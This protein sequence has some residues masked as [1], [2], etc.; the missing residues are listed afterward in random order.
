MVY[1]IIILILPHTSQMTFSY[2]VFKLYY[3]NFTYPMAKLIIQ[4]LF[5]VALAFGHFRH[6]PRPPCQQVSEF[7]DTSFSPRS[8]QFFGKL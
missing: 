4:D 2:S 8:P 6:R 3:I 5:F 1:D 7:V